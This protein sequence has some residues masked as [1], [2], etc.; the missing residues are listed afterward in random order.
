VTGKEFDDL[1]G[2]VVG[3]CRILAVAAPKVKQ[4]TATPAQR[5][6]CD[7]VTAILASCRQSMVDAIAENWD[8]FFVLEGLAQLVPGS[9]PAL[10]PIAQGVFKVAT[11]KFREESEGQ[12][13]WADRAAIAQATV[14][15]L[16]S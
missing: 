16:R 10:L 14:D 15:R 2:L 9:G 12:N 1:V 8:R 7:N 3:C 5:Q 6:A 11:R 13:L 4:G